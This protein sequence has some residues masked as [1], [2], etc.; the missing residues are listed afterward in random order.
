VGSSP[1]VQAATL[2][3]YTLLTMARRISKTSHIRIAQAEGKH[4]ALELRKR[5]WAYREIGEHFGITTAAAHLR[6]K[7]ALAECRKQ[8]EELADDVREIELQRLDRS[9]KALELAIESGDARAI[10]TSIRLA[11]RR[12][13]LLGLDTA[14]KHELSGPSGSA[15]SFALDLTKLSDEQLQKIA[16]GDSS[17]CTSEGNLGAKEEGSNSPT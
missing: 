8:T 9:L 12:A 5:G 7:T 11:E 1:S 4:D 15:V 10:D 3:W 13:R 14:Q 16:A 2:D 6:V 17:I